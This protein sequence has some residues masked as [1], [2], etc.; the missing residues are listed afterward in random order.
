MQ[1]NQADTEAGSDAVQQ[2]AP[3]LVGQSV[4][5]EGADCVG[6]M[7]LELPFI[8]DRDQQIVAKGVGRSGDQGSDVI[9]GPTP[10]TVH[11][12]KNAIPRSRR[13]AMLGKR[14]LA[15]RPQR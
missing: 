1:V 6:R 15:Q 14:Q 10:V 7:F 8:A 13:F 12:M 5:V 3:W 9:F 2:I 4:E 11:D